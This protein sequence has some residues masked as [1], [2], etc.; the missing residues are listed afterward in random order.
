MHSFVLEILLTQV[1]F[2]GYVWTGSQRIREDLADVSSSFT[3]HPYLY[4]GIV[5][6]QISSFIKSFGVSSFSFYLNLILR[7]F[8]LNT[9]LGI[10]Q[11]RYHI[12]LRKI[13]DAKSSILRK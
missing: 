3:E 10:Y 6:L 13:I 2:I 5:K 4:M 7:P 11:L 1:Q 8:N 12:K 9:I